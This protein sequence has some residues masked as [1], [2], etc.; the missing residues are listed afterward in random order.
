MSPFDP[1]RQPERTALA[2]RRTALSVLVGLVVAARLLDPVLG[3]SGVGLGGL[4]AVAGVALFV[5]AA[6]RGA[7]VDAALA[8]DGD[9]SAG[10]GALVLALLAGTCC[11]GGA[12]RGGV[13]AGAALRRGS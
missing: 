8:R 13:A 7:R 10:P 9:L 6:R 3:G 11:A 1:G 12:G 4:G 2:W 5:L